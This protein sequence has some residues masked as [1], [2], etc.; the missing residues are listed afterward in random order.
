MLNKFSKPY[1]YKLLNVN[2]FKYSGLVVSSTRIR[3]LLE[4]GNV[5]LANK[6]LSRTW[7]VDGN[8]IAGKKVGRKL[9]YRTCN[10]KI[11][12]YVIPKS[13][14]YAVKIKIG[15]K[16][17]KYGGVAYL[18]SRPTFNGNEIFLEINIFNLNKNLYKKKLRIYFL[19]FLRND[20]KFK[21]STSLIQQMKKDIIS[22]KKGLK[23][24]LVL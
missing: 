17:K 9:G 16:A 4:K 11:I 22:A 23:L 2:P 20:K 7:S 12:N 13:G 8:V 19:K 1:N 21:D 10:I 6:L 14:I 15:N 5:E 24:K 18:G 3:K